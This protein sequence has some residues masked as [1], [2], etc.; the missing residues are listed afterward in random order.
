MLLRFLRQLQANGQSH[1]AV[2]PEAREALRAFY[3]GSISLSPE[4]SEPA[5]E[6]Q[7]PQKATPTKTAKTGATSPPKPA[8]PRAPKP[9]PQVEIAGTSPEEKIAHLR[10]QAADWEPVRDLG[11]L[12]PTLVFSQGSCTADLMVIGEAPSYHDELAKAPFAGPSGDKLTGILIAMGLTR[13]EVYLTNLCKN[14]PALPGQTSNGRRARPEE[15][16]LYLP[17][18]LAEI[19]IIQPKVIVALGGAAQAI[20][21]TREPIDSLRGTWHE[22]AG[23]PMRVSQHPSFLLLEDKDTLAE[24]RKLWEDMLVVM[25]RLELAISERQRKFFL[26]KK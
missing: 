18:L 19:E 3:R 23:V 4:G 10:A 22:L 14:R 2:T 17:F 16:A 12:R 8:V 6:A 25:E 26:P 5:T 11:S 9:I 24:K 20:L 7:D 21:Q 15:V 13:P 1:I